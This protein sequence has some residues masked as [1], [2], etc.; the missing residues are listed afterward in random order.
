[1]I[2]D[3][4]KILMWHVWKVTYLRRNVV[5][6]CGASYHLLG[7]RI[8]QDSKIR[9]RLQVKSYISDWQ[10]S[11]LQHLARYVSCHNAM[12]Y[13]N[14]GIPIPKVDSFSYLGERR[15]LALSSLGYPICNTKTATPLYNNNEV[16]IK[17]CHN[18][19]T[20]GN[21]HIKQC[22]NAV[23]EWVAD[24]TL[25]V[26]HVSGKTNIA[27]IFTKE[28]CNGANFWCLRDSLM[29]RSS[30]YNKRFHSSVASSPVLVKM[31]Q[32]IKPSHPGLLKVLL[33]HH[34]F[35]IP[36]AIICLSSSGHHLLYYI[37]S[38]LPLQAHMSDPKGVLK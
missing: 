8:S 18:M 2:K 38:S 9:F 32:Y 30:N 29:C 7:S 12:A 1:M 24:G 3:I 11:E 20:K 37:T 16:C 15:Y 35:C 36:E 21:F 27:D 4:S 17:W 25:T 10:F 28:M 22:E 13:V 26:L 33:S 31:A 5:I 14:M 23:Q 34:C 6:V 19:T